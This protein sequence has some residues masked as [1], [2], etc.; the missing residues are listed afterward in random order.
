M[1]FPWVL[2]SLFVILAFRVVTFRQSPLS[3]M[4]AYVAIA[5]LP[6]LIRGPFGSVAGLPLFMV[7]GIVFYDFIY[8]KKVVFTR[9]F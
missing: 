6:I 8:I 2:A 4:Y 5:A 9:R 1:N 7:V 3:F